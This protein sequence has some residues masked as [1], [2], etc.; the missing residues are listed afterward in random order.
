MS[1]YMPLGTN[2]MDNANTSEMNDLDA[3]NV[4]N[5]GKVNIVLLPWVLSHM[6]CI[7]N[8]GLLLI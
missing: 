5:A 4:L 1:T 6:S 3:M 8:L 7:S 2:E